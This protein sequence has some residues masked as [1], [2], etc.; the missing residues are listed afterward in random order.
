MPS[1]LL[2]WPRL[3]KTQQGITKWGNKLFATEASVLYLVSVYETE[4]IPNSRKVSIT[5]QTIQNQSFRLLG[6]KEYPEK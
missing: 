4:T 6:S 1:I 3:H 5:M 2:G